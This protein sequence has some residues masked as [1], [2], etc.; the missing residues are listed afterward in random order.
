M[1]VTKGPLTCIQDSHMLDKTLVKLGASTLFEQV[2]FTSGGFRS[3]EICEDSSKF[4]KFRCLVGCEAPATSTDGWHRINPK[5]RSQAVADH[6]TTKQHC[7]N[8]KP[9]GVELSKTAQRAAYWESVKCIV[10]R[11]VNRNRSTSVRRPRPKAPES[12]AKRQKNQE[13][14]DRSE[15]KLQNVR[16]AGARKGSVMHHLL[17]LHGPAQSQGN[18]APHQAEILNQVLA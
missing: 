9:A 4:T 14:Q 2:Y 6:C 1:N 5:Q 11:A 18:L 8:C 15:A 7:M 3:V 12:E 13:K 17:N 16:E 10:S